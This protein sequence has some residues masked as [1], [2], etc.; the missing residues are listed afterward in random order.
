MMRLHK[1][2]FYF[3]SFLL[4]LTA[5]RPQTATGQ[6]FA[7]PGINQTKADL[8]HMK[9]QVLK[10]EEPYK[11]AFE[12][13][14]ADTDLAFV[15]TPYTHV[16]RGPYG[17]P[18]IGGNDLSKGAQMAYNCAVVW[19]I[20]NDKAYANKAI[21]ILDAWSATLW[22]FDYNDAKLLAA[23]TGHTLCNAAEILRFT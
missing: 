14:K 4:L 10:G 21:E 17:K 3:A 23:W 11:S 7:H 15:V 13:L 12:R 1:T 19:Y 16:L 8:A 18:N 5:I 2:T 22:D 20:T 6:G 9:A